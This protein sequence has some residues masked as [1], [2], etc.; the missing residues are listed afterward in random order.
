MKVKPFQLVTGGQRQPFIKW[1][2]Q[3]IVCSL[4]LRIAA[5][6]FKI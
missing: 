2:F 4:S 5:C 1:E 3:E 6:V